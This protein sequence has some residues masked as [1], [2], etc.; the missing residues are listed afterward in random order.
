MEFTAV[1]KEFTLDEFENS[2][3]RTYPYY[4]ITKNGFMFLVMN[5]GTPKNKESQMEYWNTQTQIIQ[6][7]NLMEHALLNKVNTEWAKSREQGKI[8]R[9]KETDALKLLLEYIKETEPNSTYIKRPN[10]CYSNYTK[11]TY[12]VLGFIEN[13]KPKVRELLDVLELNQLYIAEHLLSKVIIKGIEEKD[14]YKT[15]YQNCK[16]ALENYTKT[17]LLE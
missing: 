13:K 2:R 8:A 6:A 5:A 12:K 10:L 4:K 17:L 16:I 14:H 11:M 9:R 15:I 1:K 3:S 7:F